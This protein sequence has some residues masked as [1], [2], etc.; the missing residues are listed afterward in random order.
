MP[1]TGR[2]TSSPATGSIC[3]P[4]SASTSGEQ[5]GRETGPFSLFPLF[6][7]GNPMKKHLFPLAAA[8]L[9]AG[10]APVLA[11]PAHHHA[12][13][14]AHHAH[15]QYGDFGVDLSARDLSVRPGDDFW[16]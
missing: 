3:R 13:R 9:L 2:S 8:L 7:R 14:T 6:L 12:P 1:G 11:R 10:T 5:R 15:P 16:A 4:T